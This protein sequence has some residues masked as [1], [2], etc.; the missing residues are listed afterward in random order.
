MRSTS[1]LLAFCIPVPLLTGCPGTSPDES[2]DETADAGTEE[3]TVAGTDTGTDTGTDETADETGD[4]T[5]DTTGDEPIACER[6][7]GDGDVAWYLRCGGPTFETVAGVAV[8]AAGDLYVGFNIL[9][10]GDRAPFL[11]DDILV[12]PGEHYDFVIAKFDAEGEALW[13]QHVTGPGLQSLGTLRLC[14]DGIVISGEAE[15]GS[16]DLG[17]GPLTDRI[18]YASLD[19]DGNHRWSRGATGVGDG[20]LM[21]G[22]TVCDADGG[23]VLTGSIRDTVD[24]GGGPVPVDGLYD[25]LVARYDAAGALSW[26]RVMGNTGSTGKTGA[27]LATAAIG[28][29]G[30]VAVIGSFDGTIDPGDGPLTSTFGDDVV[31]A[32]YTASGD[33]V[34]SRQLGPEGQ[35]YGTAI[36][37][38]AGGLVTIGGMYRTG[39]TIG[40][41]SFPDVFPDAPEDEFGTLHD[42]FL[43]FLDQAGEPTSAVHLGSMLDDRVH[44]LAFD[45][46]DVLVMGAYT[47]DAYTLRAYADGVPGWMWTAPDF[48]ET[49]TELALAD[50]AVIV[51]GSPDEAVDLGDGP[52]SPRGGGD[53]LLARVRR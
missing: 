13:A 21:I 40:A 19:G 31:V 41:D 46:D 49:R 8:D 35:Q 53:L 11:I 20:H 22:D 14:G 51:A 4:T 27:G 47:D 15:E 48:G 25:G 29:D 44:D 18:W 5:G 28:P 42:G 39:I 36:A 52:T 10:F 34:W 1:L 12:T 32:L 26:T 33:L 3:T 30:S 50:G 7:T 37:V 38:D 9:E 24:L 2:T 17:G 45:A 43:G 16:V 23:L 6:H